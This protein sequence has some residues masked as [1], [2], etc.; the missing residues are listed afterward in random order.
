MAT[1][2]PTSE[3]L[4]A[5][6][7]RFLEALRPVIVG[8][9]PVIE[10][11]LTALIGGGHALLVGVP[12][13]A[14]TRLVKAVGKLLDLSFSRVQFTPDLLPSD[15]IGTEVLVEDRAKGQRRFEFR[16]GPIFA[17]L[18]LADEVNRTPPKTQAA[19]LEAM[20]ERSVTV[21]GQ[22]YDLPHP[23]MVIATQ[24][25]IEQEGTYPLPEAQLDRFMMQLDVLYPSAEDEV[26]IAELHPEDVEFSEDVKL[27]ATDIHQLRAW[28]RQ[29][30]AAP[31]ILQYATRITR[32]TRPQTPEAHPSAKK[33][34]RWGAGPR[35]LQHLIWS[36]KAR[37]L[38]RGQSHVS[39]ELIRELVVPV[40]AHRLVLQFQAEADGVRAADVLGEIVRDAPKPSD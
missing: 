33:W 28:S 7:H 4:Q 11:I 14:K 37:A 36:A 5:L 12:G 3:H 13:L 10:G 29:V 39:S 21:A 25:P 23:F 2:L 17:H 9:E 6:R 24:N 31:S 38:L 22:R 15:V 34:V 32:A 20:E 16:P 8:Q 30:L 35:A 27:T 18:V 40:L 26:R 19:V 1:N